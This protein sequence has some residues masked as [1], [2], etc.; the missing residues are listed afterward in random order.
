[1]SHENLKN[2][3]FQKIFSDYF[4]E[5]AL[6]LDRPRAATVTAKTFLKV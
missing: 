6:I 2:D 3:K 4:G 5:L 1:M